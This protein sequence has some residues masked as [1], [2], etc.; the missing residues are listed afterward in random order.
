MG[1]GDGG[2]LRYPLES[3]EQGS[4]VSEKYVALWALHTISPPATVAR[5]IHVWTVTWLLA[6]P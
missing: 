5:N 2:G 3:L 1:E 6:R 4:H